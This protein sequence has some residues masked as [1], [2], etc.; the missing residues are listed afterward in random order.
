MGRRVDPEL[1]ERI[2]QAGYKEDYFIEKTKKGKLLKRINNYCIFLSINK[3]KSKCKIYSHRPSICRNFPN[4]KVFN[5]K[6]NDPRCDAFTL[7][8]FL[9]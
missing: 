7:P 8:K 6:A 9:P 4:I 5:I 3:G 2:K 1:S